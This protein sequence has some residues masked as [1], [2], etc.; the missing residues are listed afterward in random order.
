MKSFANLC[1]R[2]YGYGILICLFVGGLMTFGFVAA[3]IV[4]GETATAICVYIHKTIFPK[5]IYLSN[6]CIIIGLV[7]MYLVGEKA[8]TAGNR[9]SKEK[10]EEISE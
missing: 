8:L 7:K 2:I 10:M 3:F 9:K 5:L 4:G 1:E 6:I